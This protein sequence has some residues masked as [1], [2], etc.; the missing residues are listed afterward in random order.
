MFNFKNKTVLLN[1]LVVLVALLIS[2]CSEVA[3]SPI[4]ESTEES[5]TAPERATEV[6]TQQKSAEKAVDI[7]VVV[8]N[9]V[10]MSSEQKKLGSKF[11]SFINSLDDLLDWRIA[12]T[13]TDVSKRGHQGEFVKFEGENRVLTPSTPAYKSLFRKTVR[14]RERGASSEQPLKATLM[15]I[16]KKDGVNSNFFRKNSDLAIIYITNEDEKSKRPASATEPY[17]VIQKVSETWPQK[18]FSAYGIIVE[19][20]DRKCWYQERSQHYGTAIYE[21]AQLTNGLTGSICAKDYG[22]TLEDIGK[23]VSALSKTFVLRAQP[24]DGRIN[25]QL[26]PSQQ[27]DWSLDGRVLTLDPPPRPGTEIRV[28]YKKANK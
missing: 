20:G 19:P 10:S 6:F 26:I 3:F 23:N 27:V 7:M 28:S 12:I 24:M 21:L 16:D 15:A 14:R 8:D 1:S 9:S 4:D 25:L 18:T 11:E 13:T 22:P 5:S 2:A 17:Q